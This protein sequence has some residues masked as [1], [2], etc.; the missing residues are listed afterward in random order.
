MKIG[1][2]SPR[3]EPAVRAYVQHGGEPP[4]LPIQPLVPELQFGDEG[5]ANEDLWEADEDFREA[6][7]EWQREKDECRTASQVVEQFAA[8][9][10][11]S[12]QDGRSVSQRRPTMLLAN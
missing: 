8:P 5:E 6:N 4:A 12:L 11:P 7:E 1:R 2:E 3:G 9:C 10:R